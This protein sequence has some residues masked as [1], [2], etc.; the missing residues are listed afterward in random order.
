[1]AWR[2]WARPPCCTAVEKSLPAAS[3]TTAVPRFDDPEPLLLLQ[4][5][6]LQ[7]EAPKSLTHL[8]PQRL[9]LYDV[10]LK[11][12][13]ICDIAGIQI[14]SSLKRAY[15]TPLSRQLGRILT[16]ITQH[17]IVLNRCCYR[18]RSLS[19]RVI[20]PARM[21]GMCSCG[22]KFRQLWLFRAFL[23]LDL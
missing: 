10:I 23:F 22:T 19:N 20:S 1:M 15:L 16:G 12:S 4:P 11:L 18:W 9:I 14:F 21:G 3:W 7:L 5:P 17:L 13:N 8:T 6:N 2:L